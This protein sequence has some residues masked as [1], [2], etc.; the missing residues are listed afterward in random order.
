MI[1]NNVVNNKFSY[2]KYS[3][4]SENQTILFF[5]NADS[6]CRSVR[7][8]CDKSMK[9]LKVKELNSQ[10]GKKGDNKWVDKHGGK[11]YI[12][13]MVEGNWSCIISI[14]SEK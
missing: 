9:P 8:V 4:N 11:S 10:F 5:L 12:I 13:E 7:I 3:D 2:L 1:Y 6:V 14:E